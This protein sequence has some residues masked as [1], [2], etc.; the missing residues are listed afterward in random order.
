MKATGYVVTN[1]QEINEAQRLNLKIPEPIMAEK[2]ILLPVSIILLAFIDDGKI[3]TVTSI[4][5]EL[6]FKYEEKVW[7]RIEAHLEHL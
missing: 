2:E 4:G 5:R 3:K 7:K 6:H 1:Q